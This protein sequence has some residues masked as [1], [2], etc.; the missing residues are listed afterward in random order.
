MAFVASW[1]EK[2]SKKL[3]VLF[4]YL[5]T[6]IL[7]AIL[8][9]SGDSDTKFHLTL[10]STENFGAEAVSYAQKLGEWEKEMNKRR[11]PNEPK[12]IV[13]NNV[14][15]ALFSANTSFFTIKRQTP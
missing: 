12:I 9:P 1:N 8:H 11:G 15:K 13:E 2:Y 5:L 3:V 14:L 4:S 7:A 10:M 6:P